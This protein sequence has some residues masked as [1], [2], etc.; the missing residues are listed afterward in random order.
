MFL[1]M[2]RKKGKLAIQ[3]REKKIGISLP[4][5]TW[6]KDK[7]CPMGKGGGDPNY[8]FGRNRAGEGAQSRSEKKKGRVLYSMSPGKGS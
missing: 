5:I 7:V 2:R 6:G 3:V 4:Q 8:A 1:L